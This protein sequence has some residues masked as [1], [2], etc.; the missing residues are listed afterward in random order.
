[1]GSKFSPSSGRRFK[2]WL[3]GN[4]DKK[5]GVGIL[6][7]EECCKIFFGNKNDIG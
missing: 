7:R 4:E 5:G 1:M 3:S 2:L 6:V